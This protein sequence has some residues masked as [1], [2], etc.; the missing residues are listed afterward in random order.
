MQMIRL[1]NLSQYLVQV[2]YLNEH[3]TKQVCSVAFNLKVYT[4]HFP[5]RLSD[6]K[7]IPFPENLYILKRAISGFRIL[8]SIIGHFHIT[9]DLI[10]INK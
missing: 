7:D 3:K 10:C 6:V 9:E 8:H 2:T 4:E 5:L 1:R